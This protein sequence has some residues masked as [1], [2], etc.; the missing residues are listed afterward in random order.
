MANHVL[1]DVYWEEVL[2]VMNGKVEANELGGYGGA[3]GP[4]LD[5]FSIPIMLGLYDLLHEARVNEKSFFS[6][7]CHDL[8]LI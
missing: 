4:S 7:T 5:G 1:G 2:P 8:N 3:P 6:G